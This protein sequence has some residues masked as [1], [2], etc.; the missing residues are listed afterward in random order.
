MSN[1]RANVKQGTVYESITNYASDWELMFNNARQYNEDSSQIFRDTY[2]L[3]QRFNTALQEAVHAHGI[4]LE[5]PGQFF[6][7]FS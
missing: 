6:V 1:I 5:D 3:Q 7:T 2:T 4:D